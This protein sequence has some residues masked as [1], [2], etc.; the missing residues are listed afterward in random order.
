MKV[1]KSG[2]LISPQISARFKTAIWSWLLPNFYAG[3][4]TANEDILALI[5][6]L[7]PQDC[8]LDLIRVGGKGDGGYLIP[9]DLSGIEF[10]FSPGVSNVSHFE[11]ELADLNI[12]SFLADYSVDS[13]AIIRPELTF[14]KQFLG[15]SDYGVYFTLETWKN[16][17]LREYSGDLL[18]QMD[19]EGA[20]YEVILGTSDSLLSQFRIIVVEFHAL[21]RFFDSFAFRLMSACFEKLL[22]S[23]V[24]VHLHPNNSAGI[25][26]SGALEIPRLMEFTFLNRKRIIKTKPQLDF[27]HK[28]DEDNFLGETHIA[29]PRCWYTG[30]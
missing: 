11:D 16:K 20:E 6:K 27:P 18:L 10:C 29:L 5:A 15:A 21:N 1:L 26:A 24:V 28:L 22:K 30:V 25:E 3:R 12:R 14:D 19:I 8:G 4:R 23:F 17:Y 2:P 9:N 7:R 13:P